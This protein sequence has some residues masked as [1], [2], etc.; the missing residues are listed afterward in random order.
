M[1]PQEA[2]ALTNAGECF[3]ASECNTCVIDAAWMLTRERQRYHPPI[4]ARIHG[5][6]RRLG[7]E[8]PDVLRSLSPFSVPV[9]RVIK[10]TPILC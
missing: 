1:P 5:D 9:G 6:G 4:D 8:A 7:V 3:G 2:Q 10:A